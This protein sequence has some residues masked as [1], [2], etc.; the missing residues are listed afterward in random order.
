MSIRYKILKLTTTTFG[1]TLLA[2]S[3]FLGTT[4]I[5]VG[6]VVPLWQMGHFDVRTNLL[7]QPSLSKWTTE[8]FVSKQFSVAYQLLNYNIK[9]GTSSTADEINKFD[10]FFNIDPWIEE[11]QKQ[12]PSATKL[13]DVVVSIDTKSFSNFDNTTRL[14]INIA[15]KPGFTWA[16]YILGSPS[17]EDDATNSVTNVGNS[18]L[19]I[20]LKGFNAPLVFAVDQTKPF[21]NELVL[22]QKFDK[23]KSLSDKNILLNV[24][25]EAVRTGEPWNDGLGFADY[26]EDIS[27]S[28]VDTNEKYEN[29]KK[30]MEE[31]NLESLNLFDIINHESLIVTNSNDQS[32][33]SLWKPASNQDIFYF[34]NSL[35]LYSWTVEEGET[36]GIKFEFDNIFRGGLFE[37]IPAILINN[38]KPENKNTNYT[39]FNTGQT[40]IEFKFNLQALNGIGI[41]GEK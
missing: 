13:S 18:K 37:F 23:W 25:L 41:E 38:N 29:W 36:I 22:K 31:K 12:D 14:N 6:T 15:L 20:N 8:E 28:D 9:I 2:S 4:G 11:L 16:R 27:L 10:K 40:W 30:F 39:D 24:F 21:L 19:Q 26:I 7:P 5:I 17:S 1:A 34:Y 32:D 3:V 35:N 33:Y